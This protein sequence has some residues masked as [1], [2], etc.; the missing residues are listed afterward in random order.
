MNTYGPFYSKLCLAHEGHSMGIFIWITQPLRPQLAGAQ[1]P[2]LVS[3]SGRGIPADWK[4]RGHLS[5]RLAHYQQSIFRTMQNSQS[6][7]NYFKINTRPWS[8]VLPDQWKVPDSN[9]R[10]LM[11]GGPPL[12]GILQ[13]CHLA[14]RVPGPAQHICSSQ[15]VRVS[16]AIWGLGQTS[17]CAE[18]IGSYGGWTD[19]LDFLSPVT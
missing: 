3:S 9:K 19:D 14:I 18:L 5:S 12:Q 4:A 7:I 8:E 1:P 2:P 11:S 6:L 15:L 17:L 13:D 10:F 16:E